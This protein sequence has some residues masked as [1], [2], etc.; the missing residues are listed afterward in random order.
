MKYFDNVRKG[1]PFPIANKSWTDIKVTLTFCKH[2]NDI[3]IGVHGRKRKDA[4]S[5]TSTD[6]I[7]IIDSAEKLASV[8]DAKIKVPAGAIGLRENDGEFIVTDE[9]HILIAYSL[10]ENGMILWKP[11]DGST[12]TYLYASGIFK[13]IAETRKFFDDVLKWLK[14]NDLHSIRGILLAHD[15]NLL[16]D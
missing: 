5:R 3:K 8:F 10:S 13:N 14:T 16:G 4:G 12:R 6:P 11:L 7:D 9:Q 15:L 1:T 2:E